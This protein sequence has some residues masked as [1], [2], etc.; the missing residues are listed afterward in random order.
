MNKRVFVFVLSVA[1][2]LQPVLCAAQSMSDDSLQAS[3]Q[4][5]M[6]DSSQQSSEDSSQQSSEQSTQESSQQS[7]EQSTQDSSNQSSEQSSDQTTGASSV[8]TSD[9]T[10]AS[11]EMT[12]EM[13]DGTVEAVGA[14]SAFVLV[15]GGAAITIG[16]TVVGVILIVRAVGARQEDA[17][18]LQDQI[19]AGSGPDYE[20]LI[21]ELGVTEAEL[22]RANDELV[23][24]GYV[25]ENDQ[26]AADYLVALLLK[27]G[28]VVHIEVAEAS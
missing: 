24:E 9:A 7:S 11:T 12:V 28:S 21:R 18:A 15:V 4:D 10:L 25:I 5:S 22:V 19:Y 20:T 27:L 3:S 23:A 14:S 2:V 17:I 8:G 16:V 26:D 1:C 6:Q 13:T